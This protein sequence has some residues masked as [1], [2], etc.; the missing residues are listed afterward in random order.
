MNSR[1]NSSFPPDPEPIL[2]EVKHSVGIPVI[3]RWINHHANARPDATALLSPGRRPLS[4]GRMQAQ[5]GN[6]IGSLNALGLGKA[7]RVAMVLPNGPEMAVAFLAVASG[8]TCAPLNPSYRAREFE[9]YL[10]SLKARALLVQSS[11]DTAAR[12]VAQAMGIPVLELVPCLDEE[13]GVFTITGDFPSQKSAGCFAGAADTALLL[14][15]SGTTGRQKIAAVTQANMVAM[16]KNIQAALDLTSDDRLLNIMPLYHLHGLSVILATVISGGSVVCPPG[17]LAPLF[18]GWLADFKPTWYSAAPALHQAILARAPTEGGGLRPHSLR[19]IRSISAHLPAKVLAELEQQFGVPVIEGW[20][21]TEACAS[22]SNMFHGEKRRP[23]SVG[24]PV[25]TEIGIINEQGEFVSPGTLGEIVVRGPNV[26]PAYAD[27]S[28]ATA[29]AFINGWLKSGDLGYLDADGFL[30]MTGRLKEMINRG[31]EKIS[32]DEVDAI[33]LGHPA[34]LEAVTFGTPDPKLGEEVAAA[35]VIRNEVSLTPRQIREFASQHLADFKVPRRVLIV[36][37]IPRGSTGKIERLKMA[38]KFRLVEAEAP[39]PPKHAPTLPRTSLEKQLAAIWSEVL[40]LEITSIYDGF[41]RLGGD[42]ILAAQILSRVQQRLGVQ[43]PYVS[44]YE[45][46]MDIAKMAVLV[47]E[48]QP[49]QLQPILPISR[50]GELPLSFAQQRLWFLDQFDPGNPLYNICRAVRLEG[51]LNLNALGKTLNA[52]VA[53]HET[54]RTTFKAVNGSPVA[55]IKP[56]AEVDVSFVDLSGLAESAQDE[57]VRRICGQTFRKPFDLSRDVMLRASVLKLNPARHVL[58]LT[59]H[60]IAADG[61]SMSIVFRELSAFY[62]AYSANVEPDLPPLPVQ[63]ADYAGWQSQWLQGKV[64]ED[65]MAYW[66]QHLSGELPTLQ[67]PTDRP[68]SSQETFNGA[69]HHI[70]LPE[71]LTAALNILSQ[72]EDATLFMTLLAAFKTLLHR[73]SGQTD[74]RVGTPIANRTRI[75]IEGV[76]GFFVNTLVMRTDCSGDPSFR[77]LLRRVR[78]GSLQAFAHQDMP[79]E[80][81]VEQMNPIRD[82]SHSPLFNVLF[83][84][85]NTPPQ[86]PNLRGLDLFPIDADSG[87][88]KFDLSLYITPV[89]GGL[90]CLIEYN[91]DLFEKATIARMLEHFQVLLQALAANPNQRI[92]QMPMLLET[93]RQQLLWKWNE[94]CSSYPADKCLHTIFESQVERTPDAVAIVFDNKSLTYRELN[95]R[96]NQLAH[97]LG[98]LGVQ[99]EVLVGICLNRSEEMVVALLAVLKA[100][101]AYVP[102]DP[103]YPTDRLAFMLEDAALPVLLTQS[104]LVDKI[105]AHPTRRLLLDTDWPIIAGEANTP[106]AS[107]ATALNLAYMLYTSGSTGK[108]KGVQIPH[109][110]VVNFLYSMKQTPGM[111]AQDTLLAITTLSFDIA[112]LELWLPL[113]LGARVVIA[114]R[115]T[116]LDGRALAELLEGCGAT[117][118]QATPSTWRMLLAAGWPGNRRL[119]ILCGGEPWPKELADQLLDKCQSFWN[120]Y[121]PTETTIWST[122]GQVL[123]GKEILLGR[124]IANTRVYLLDGYLQPVPIGVPGELHIGGAGLARGYLNRPDLTAEKFIPDPFDTSGNARL[125]KTGDLARYLPDGQIEYLGRIDH[126]VKIRGFRIELGEI[127]SALHQ[128]PAVK[129]AAVLAREGASD[130]KRLVAYVVQN[131]HYTGSDANQLDEERISEWKAIWDDTYA[132]PEPTRDPS[133][134]IAGWQSSYSGE[135]IPELEM[136]EWVDNT[137]AR[138]RS[139][140]PKRIL[141]LGCG[142]GLLLFRLAPSCDHYCGLDFSEKALENVRRAYV[143]QGGDLG[144]LTL[145][146][147]AADE[148]DNLDAGSFDTVILNS[149]IQYFPD[150]DYVLR[151][152]EKS[153]RV[154]KPGGSIFLGDVRNFRLLEAFHASIQLHRASADLPINELQ[155][156]IRKYMSQEE[157]LLIAPEFFSAVKSR[158]PGITDV[159]IQVKG[160]RHHN[161]LTRFRY[162]VVLRIGSSPCTMGDCPFVDWVEKGLTVPALRAHLA[163]QEPKSLLVTGI[164][165]ARLQNE[166]KLLEHLEKQNGLTTVSD[167]REAIGAADGNPGVEPEDLWK[168]G[169]QLPYSVIIRQSAPRLDSC[170]ALFVHRDSSESARVPNWPHN[171]DAVQLKRLNEYANNPLQAIFNRK[172]IPGLRNLLKSKLPDYMVPS[173]YILMDA[174]PLTPNGKLDRKALPAPDKERKDLHGAYIPPQTPVEETLCGIWR[175]VLDLERV[176]IKDNFFDLGGHSLLATQVISRLHKAFNIS[177]P[178]RSLFDAPTIASLASY[179]ETLRW[180][181]HSDQP[182]TPADGSSREETI[183]V[184]ELI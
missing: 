129:T 42:S 58:L 148:L 136:R 64:L 122:V 86:I 119:K 151:V 157:E 163:Q 43:L 67:L 117:I 116:A 181:S 56:I 36:P 40:G 10:R 153:G 4:Y 3:N 104:S 78:E 8:A 165:N 100:G 99:P 158:V 21:L 23:G 41:S 69:T 33:L 70:V 178:L 137:V 101:G 132:S 128:H 82:C 108:P 149:V 30:F 135:P 123:R 18:F 147:R 37:E 72:Q 93:E 83:V 59:L 160:G 120:M 84:V 126:Q 176:G 173:E 57:E 24:V 25:G 167:L 105:P 141:E 79:F 184:E 144:R 87:T 164:P 112:G 146:Q 51:S 29:S 28:S 6:V 162:D 109:Q 39:A 142:T 106:C 139:L 53:R 68:H 34:I 75:E 172:L 54:L 50:N 92:S 159:E 19:R 174:M 47:E 26:I 125:Y 13:A 175:E 38:E 94:T 154:V 55:V 9:F 85:Q 49:A 152:L 171:P 155:Q 20:G 168:L 14:H 16:G 17:F 97:Y 35:V 60:H 183:L 143:K 15:T 124:P 131:Q 145:L 48:T 74:I 179:V 81:L 103:N 2:E 27:D 156:R 102:M 32:P 11:L 140:Q 65:Q 1:S 22:T 177:L 91:T 63:F 12:S 98:K 45:E 161:E 90:K 31:G 150:I 121:G 130:E 95:Q 115:E 5:V 133:F 44:F 76:I 71:T 80:K 52:I 118:M 62:G 127:E 73:C 182:I 111:T 46:G 89:S 88:A 169:A 114:K 107:N 110:A 113:I 7:D 96:A 66:K 166:M 180:A 138:I 61:W 77:D 170:D 134:N